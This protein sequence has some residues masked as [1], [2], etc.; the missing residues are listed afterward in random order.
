MNT[1][2]ELKG[3]GPKT[4]EL[5]EKINIKTIE[6]LLY[7]YPKKYH[8]IERTNMQNIAEGS[9]VIIDGIVDG[10]PTM[11][12]L[13]PKLKKIIIRVS[14][15]R[16]IYNVQIYNQIYL[17]HELSIGT[18]ITVI[19][20]YERNRN[21]ITAT[22]IRKGLLPNKPYIESIYHSTSD[23]NQKTIIKYIQLALKSGVTIKDEIPEYLVKKYHFL[24]KM[25]SINQ[26]H[27]PSD[28]LSFKKSVQRLKYEEFYTYLYKIK[29]LKE[30]RLH[31]EKAIIRTINDKKIDKL[32]KELP[33]QL[34]K[35]QLKT[36][37]EIKK[38]LSTK[39]RMNR[40][41]QGDVGSGKTIVAFFA[42]YMNYLS[43]YQTALMV[44][45]EIL[46]SQ[47]FENAKNFFKNINIKIELLTSSTKNKK[48][49]YKAISEGEID[50]IIG[51]QSLIQKKLKYKNLGL[52]I[53]DEQHRFGVNQREELKNKGIFPDVLSMS[54][55]P[56]PRTYY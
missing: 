51:T 23:L 13:G 38:D 7:Y 21:T 34:T 33:F 27:N 41:I 29:L 35:D 22:E 47:H 1:I 18:K 56:I 53:T 43:G 16:N 24:N 14:N 36:I 50:F 49:I 20:K 42:T 30:K 44:P 15:N 55:T 40:L 52:I 39:I 45:T 31:N 3:I 12:S 17:Y 25:E 37:E 9:K 6:D 8:I 5:F 26:I 2:E 11:I 48:N 19:G 10:K 46:A 32:K 4:K 54:A 28:I